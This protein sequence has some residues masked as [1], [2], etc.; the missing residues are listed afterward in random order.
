MDAKTNQHPGTAN[1]EDKAVVDGAG[2]G[3]RLKR[4]TDKNSIK[5]KN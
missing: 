3:D 1:W 4:K 5:T 2:G